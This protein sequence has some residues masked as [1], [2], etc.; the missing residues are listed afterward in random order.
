MRSW[1][2]FASPWWCSTAISEWVTASRSFYRMFG[3]TPQETQ[4]RLFLEL[5]SGQWN[6]PALRTLLEEVI[7]RH[8]T[9]EA[10]E[11]EHEFPSLGRRFLLLNARQVVDEL[12]P[13]SRC[14]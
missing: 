1:T 4:G 12:N 10:Y 13:D 2:P 3:A 7:P 9:I 11:I 6:I 8:R 14:C 5:D